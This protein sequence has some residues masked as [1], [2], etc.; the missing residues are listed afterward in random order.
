M[1]DADARLVVYDLNGRPVRH[2]LKATVAAGW[3]ELTW[4]GRDDAGRA[5]P[6]GAYF[7]RLEL[8]DRTLNR[9]LLLRR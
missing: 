1:R 7:Y 6:A 3:T 9:K 8:G 2:L 5:L 4:D